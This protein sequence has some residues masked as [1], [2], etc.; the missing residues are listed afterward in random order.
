M[1]GAFS[2]PPTAPPT[3]AIPNQASVWADVSHAPGT[4]MTGLTF[5]ST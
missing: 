4:A 2:V 1:V 3:L 5:A